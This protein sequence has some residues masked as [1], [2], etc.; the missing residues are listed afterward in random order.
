MA[1]RVP[2]QKKEK[3]NL[4]VILKS[5]WGYDKMIGS[6]PKVVNKF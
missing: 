5:A 6:K 1:G 2:L 4:V 3:K